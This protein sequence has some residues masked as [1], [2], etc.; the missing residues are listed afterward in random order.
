MQTDGVFRVAGALAGILVLSSSISWGQAVGQPT[1]RHAPATPGVV[2]GH[3]TLEDTGGPARFVSVTLQP[4]VAPTTPA[5]TAKDKEHSEGAVTVSR[6]VHTTLDGSFLIPSVAPGNYYVMADADPYV[7]AAGVL[8]REQMDHPTKE[9]AQRMA[10]L[11]VPVSV[12]SGKTSTAEV[13]LHRGA[14]LSGTVRFDDGTPFAASVQLLRKDDQGVWKDFHAHL[15]GA[16]L[17]WTTRGVFGSSVCLQDRT[18][19]VP[20]SP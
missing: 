20:T 16:L 10:Q 5:V 4:V 12:A 14:V 11:L 18:G 17:S 8:T 7:S 3:V 19:C 9:I 1:V 6:V 15:L 2:T 13:R